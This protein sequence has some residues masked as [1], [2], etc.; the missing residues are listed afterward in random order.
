MQVALLVQLI[1]LPPRIWPKA[2]HLDHALL[3]T[4]ELRVCIRRIDSQDAV[5]LSLTTC[6][7]PVIALDNQNP[8]SA[9]RRPHPTEHK[10]DTLSTPFASNGKAG[11]YLTHYM[12]RSTGSPIQERPFK[13]PRLN[14]GSQGPIISPAATTTRIGRD[15]IERMERG[16]GLYNWTPPGTEDHIEIGAAL[17]QF[18]VTGRLSFMESAIPPSVQWWSLTYADD[19]WES[20]SS[21]YANNAAQP[22]PPVSDPWGPDVQA[23]HVMEPSLLTEQHRMV[24]RLAPKVSPDTTWA[25]HSER[26]SGNQRWNTG[27]AEVHFRSMMPQA[28]TGGTWNA[29]TLCCTNGSTVRP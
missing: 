4:A 17:P 23:R 3:L 6:E 25:H 2:S 22:A 14:S 28:L 11:H 24:D 27:S 13:R 9:E 29:S 19:A 16:N 7:E 5:G 12:G 26:V 18:N 15:P 21:A 10:Q 20:G 8:P 1:T